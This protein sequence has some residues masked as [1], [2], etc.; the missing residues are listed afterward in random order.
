MTSSG[1]VLNVESR[2]FDG[3]VHRR[4]E[5]SVSL[6]DQTQV[7]LEGAFS[8]EVRHSLLGTIEKGTVSREYYWW[9]RAYS[10]FEFRRL[11]G[12]LRNY[13]CNLN[14]PPI[15][16]GNTLSFVDLDVDVIVHQDGSYEVVDLDEFETNKIRLGY[17]AEIER[18][19]KSGLA[20]LL[21]MIESAE[22][23]FGFPKAK[24][25][26]YDHNATS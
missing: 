1:T 15:I 19:V 21:R 23:P 20:E 10:I 26:E 3:S 4:W 22:F 6:L 18:T 8:E 14:L 17:T 5:A 16:E 9:N 25:N 13:Y 2:K 12:T 24:Q 7:I 11:D